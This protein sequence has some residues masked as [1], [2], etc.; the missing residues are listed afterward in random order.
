MKTIRMIRLLTA[1]AWT[2][3]CAVSCCPRQFSA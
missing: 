3:G 1:I 2:E